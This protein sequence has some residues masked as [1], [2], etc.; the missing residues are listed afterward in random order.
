MPGKYLKA[1]F[2][3]RRSIYTHFSGAGELLIYNYLAPEKCLYTP[4]TGVDLSKILGGQTK[5][6]GEKVVKSDKCMGVSQLLGARSR[7]APQSTPMD[8]GFAHRVSLMIGFRQFL[9]KRNI[10]YFSYGIYNM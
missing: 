4:G 6:L 3:R 7:A 2:R 8:L 5:I 9:S 1:P 10:Y